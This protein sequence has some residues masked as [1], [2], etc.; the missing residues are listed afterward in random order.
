MPCIS[1]Q[2]TLQG[3]A[4]MQG[5]LVGPKNSIW[6][7][8]CEDG[9]IIQI[10][11][12]CDAVGACHD[13]LHVVLIRLQDDIEHFGMTWLVYCKYGVLFPFLRAADAG[14]AHQIKLPHI[15]CKIARQHQEK[16]ESC[17]QGLDRI[18]L[19]M[20]CT[21]YYLNWS[22]LPRSQMTQATAFDG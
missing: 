22:A 20:H 12:A 4:T 3:S 10:L 14:D 11:H 16:Y 21:I 1:G 6:V 15:P 5:R 8:T 19:Q 13:G 17:M 9:R 7:P 2:R 18:Q